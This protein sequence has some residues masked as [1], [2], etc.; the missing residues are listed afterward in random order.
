MTIDNKIAHV[1]DGLP[2]YQSIGG[3]GHIATTRVGWTLGAGF[4]WRFSPSMSVKAEYL[5]FDL[6]RVGVASAIADSTASRADALAPPVYYINTAAL[7]GATRF[8]GQI[9]RLGLNYHFDPIQAFPVL[10][11]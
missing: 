5:Y 3:I 10:G 11:R 9:A 7:A 8:A 2:F 6:G 4:E 1:T